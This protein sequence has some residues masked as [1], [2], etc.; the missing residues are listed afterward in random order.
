MTTDYE[1]QLEEEVFS[2][3]NLLDTRTKEL[4]EANKEIKQWRDGLKHNQ[5]AGMNTIVPDAFLKIADSDISHSTT[6]HINAPEITIGGGRLTENDVNNLHH[7]WCLHMQ[8]EN[9]PPLL[10]RIWR[11]IT[12]CLSTK[13][14]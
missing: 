6:F 2:L 3:K 13:K 12:S 14:S 1:K 8:R 4:D 9:N 7:L 10:Y 5:L 11:K